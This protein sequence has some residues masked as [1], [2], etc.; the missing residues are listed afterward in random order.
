MI[1]HA[2]E[3]IVADWCMDALCFDIVVYR[4]DTE[5]HRTQVQLHKS[6]FN[7]LIRDM[8]IAKR[9]FKRLDDGMEEYQR[10]SQEIQPYESEDLL[11]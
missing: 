3:N 9:E 8:L 4:D 7:Q 1:K 11:S 5:L 2:L 10:L 6:H